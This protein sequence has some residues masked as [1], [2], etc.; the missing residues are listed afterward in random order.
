[1]PNFVG[2]LKHTVPSTWANAGF[3]GLVTYSSPMQGNDV[4]GTQSI[5][6]DSVVSCSSGI[7]LGP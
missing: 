6:K 4:I 1:V 3:T 7:T 5:P 2:A